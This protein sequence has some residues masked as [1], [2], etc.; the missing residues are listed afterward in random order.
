[1]L[2]WLQSYWGAVVPVVAILGGLRGLAEKLE[3]KIERHEPLRAWIARALVIPSWHDRY[4]EWLGRQLDRLQAGM[5]G[6]WSARAFSRCFAIALA[7]PAALMLASY[8]FGGPGGVGTTV[9]LPAYDDWRQPTLGFGLLIAMAG[10]GRRE[11]RCP[12]GGHALLPSRPARRR[13][14]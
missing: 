9:F 13:R 6:L 5:G 14:R 3:Q 4:I 8:G 10:L 11:H 12:G 2:D 1:V 7:Y